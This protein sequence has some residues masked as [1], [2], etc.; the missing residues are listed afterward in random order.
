MA[1]GF[2]V[3]SGWLGTRTSRAIRA[4]LDL[5]SA[6]EGAADSD[7][8]CVSAKHAWSSLRNFAAHFQTGCAEKSRTS[9]NFTAP[10]PLAQYSSIRLRH[11]FAFAM[12][13]TVRYPRMF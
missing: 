9:A 12:H 6:G 8:T 2:S 11:V 10:S 13:P 7:V 3:G 4:P 1:T 5:T